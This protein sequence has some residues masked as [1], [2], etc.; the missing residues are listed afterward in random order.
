MQ[1]HFR[2]ITNTVQTGEP[3]LPLWRV[4]APL[5]HFSIKLYYIRSQIVQTDLKVKLHHN[6]AQHRL[7]AGSSASGMAQI[8]NLIL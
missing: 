6:L 2:A 1:R 7:K 8:K 3:F 5:N 4:M